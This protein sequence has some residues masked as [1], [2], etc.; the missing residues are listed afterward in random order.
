[1][2]GCGN[3]L[4]FSFI[5]FSF[6]FEFQE[7]LFINRR[8]QQS[9]KTPPPMSLEEYQS[10]LSDIELLLAESPD[11]ESLLKLKTDLEELIELTK[12]E[13]GSADAN[14]DEDGALEDTGNSAQISSSAQ[15]EDGEKGSNQETDSRAVASEP[16]P[17]VVG[18]EATSTSATS[19]NESSSLPSSSAAAATATKSKTSIKKSK[20]ILSKPFEIPNHLIPLDSD[21]DAERK[22]KKRTIRA[23]KAQYKSTQKTVES[24]V[25]QQSWQDFNK[26]TKKKRK[27]GAGGSIFQTEDGIGA[28]VGVISGSVR[29]MGQERTD[30]K[31]MNN[32]SAGNKKQRHLF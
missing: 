8:V 1:M 12:D 22:R 6:L 16:A 5:P 7:D 2:N 3:I 20:K 25:K 4:E 24:E 14:A 32:A 10:Q 9:L 23:L 15:Q 31:G 13:Q 29:V 27:G 26:K 28:R 30:V 19:T 18:S 17:A 11:D 21:T